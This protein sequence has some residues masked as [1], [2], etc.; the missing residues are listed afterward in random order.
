MMAAA[1][2]AVALGMSPEGMRKKVQKSVGETALFRRST[3]ASDGNVATVENDDEISELRAHNRAL[4]DQIRSL[5]GKPKGRKRCQ[6]RKCRKD[7]ASW[8]EKCR[9][10]AFSS[11]GKIRCYGCKQCRRAKKREKVDDFRLELLVFWNITDQKAF[12]AGTDEFVRLTKEEEENVHYGF[13]FNGNEAVCKEAYTGAQGFLDHL[14]N[15]DT[16]LGA[17]LTAASI[18]KIEAHGPQEEVDKLREPLAT[19][20]VEYWNFIGNPFFVPA[21][22]TSKESHPQDT[23]LTLLVHW[24]VA[25]MPAFVKGAAAFEDLTKLEPGN[26]FYGFTQ[27]GDKLAV[28]K[29]AYTDAASFLAHLGNVGVPLGNTGPEIASISRIEAHG[30]QAELDALRVPLEAFN[31]SYWALS[32]AA[33]FVTDEYQAD[34]EEDDV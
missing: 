20:P 22:Y 30:P 15:V 16:P 29:E 6:K 5:G 26:K 9:S 31:T 4:Q 33:F 10:E 12:V 34:E 17:A 28:C 24:A 8:T 19:F 2:M 27:N 32:D 1:A 11:S 25:D 13:T 7:P 14:T 23:T 3:I 18:Y 21:Q